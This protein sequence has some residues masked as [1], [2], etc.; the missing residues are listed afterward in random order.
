M[1]SDPIGASI[2]ARPSRRTFLAL[3]AT[4]AVGALACGEND[5]LLQNPGGGDARL[6]SR[7]GTP[8]TSSAPG[9]YLITASNENDGTLFIPDSATSAPMP[10]VVALHGA[11]QGATWGRTLLEPYARSRGFLLLSPGARGLTWDVFSSRFS[12]DVTF[13]NSALAWTF[14][15]RAVD[16]SRITLL[17]FSDGATYALGLGAANG[18]L[19]S[20][21]VACSPGFVARSSSPAVG[22][23]KFFLSHGR[24]DQVLP[25]DGAS[26]AIVPALRGQGYDVT[27]EEFDGGHGIPAAVLAKALDWAGLPVLPV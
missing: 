19:F 12:Y 2:M 25:I 5:P 4:G 24:Q 26:R 1:L 23:P 11:G 21:I 10:L 16:A 22:K 18:D 7:P 9:S 8:A 3:L 13:I 15:Q 17:G 14:A 27:Y 6:T 20:R